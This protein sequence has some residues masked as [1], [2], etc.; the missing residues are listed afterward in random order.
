[1]TSEMKNSGVIVF[2]AIMTALGGI[3][4][5]AFAA[6]INGLASVNWQASEMIRRFL[7]A[8]GYLDEYEMLGD[9]CSRVEGTE[10]LL[11]VSFLAVVLVFCNYLNAKEVPA[12]EATA[13]EE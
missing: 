8:N 12:V 7:V 1:M 4:G 5:W 10:Y 3:F 2:F 9:F 6:L 13:A 11:V